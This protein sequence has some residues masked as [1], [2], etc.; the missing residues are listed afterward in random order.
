MKC[1]DS[2]PAAS[3]RVGEHRGALFEGQRLDPAAERIR[4]LAP[5]EDG[6]PVDASTRQLGRDPLE[7]RGV[8][9]IGRGGPP[10]VGEI[11]ASAVPS[12]P[13]GLL[14]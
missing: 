7:P 13:A 10:S 2:G 12:R 14:L 9:G 1:P 6:Q 11:E 5:A 8:M 4:V 3:R